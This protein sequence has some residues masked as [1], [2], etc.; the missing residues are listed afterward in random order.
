MKAADGRMTEV[1][2]EMRDADG[3]TAATDRQTDG[4]R[5]GA[6]SDEEGK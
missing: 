4:R 3:Q 2:G 6:T 1:T 5:K